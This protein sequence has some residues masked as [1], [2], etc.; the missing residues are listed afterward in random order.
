MDALSSILAALEPRGRVF[1]RGTLRSPW[2]LRGGVPMP[3]FHAIVRGQGMVALPDGTMREVGGGDLVLLPRGGVHVLADSPGTE[4]VDLATAVCRT[5]GSSFGD[6]SRDGDGPSTTII[7]GMFD[8]TGGSHPLIDELPDVLVVHCGIGRWLEMTLDLLADELTGDRPGCELAAGRLCEILLVH[9]LRAHL[10]SVASRGTGFATAL[11]DPA[12]GRALALIHTEQEAGWRAATL[13]D[14]VGMSR[15]SF[16]GRFKQLVG[17]PPAGYITRI[18]MQRAAALLSEA[19][20]TI[21]VAALA[22]KLGYGSESAFGRAFTQ[23][24]GQSPGAY[25][26]SHAS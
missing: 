6:V 8:F 11:A 23:F 2:G 24:H 1:C 3:M 10:S 14:R 26:R 22:Q 12:I 20:T 16:F 9:C 17:E 13:A 18:A 5:P 21:T 25:K 7:C 4:P 19:G 15:S